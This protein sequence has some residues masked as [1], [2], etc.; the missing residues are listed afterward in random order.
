MPVVA[1]WAVIGRAAPET[2]VSKGRD[3]THLEDT[4]FNI[5]SSRAV[6]A[7]PSFHIAAVLFN[8]R[9]PPRSGQ[10][11]TAGEPLMQP[12]PHRKTIRT[13]LWRRQIR[14]PLSNEPH[15]S[16]VITPF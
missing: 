1:V 9:L 8:V 4:Y 11:T 16:D 6:L 13:P 10:I 5:I 12:R 2:M 3:N 15:Q 14:S 7:A